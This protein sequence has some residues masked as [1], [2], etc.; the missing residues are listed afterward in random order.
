MMNVNSAKRFK[1]L[2][3]R[4]ENCW[5]ME[6]QPITIQEKQTMIMIE[7]MMAVMTTQTKAIMMVIM[8]RLIMV[9]MLVLHGITDS[10]TNLTIVEIGGKLW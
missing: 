2:K 4:N 6:M 8:M 10:I 5:K 9:T 7:M 1:N 3:K